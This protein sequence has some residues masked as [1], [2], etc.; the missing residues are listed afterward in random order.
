MANWKVLQKSSDVS[1]AKSL[2]RL[3]WQGS[4]K[5]QYELICT[6]LSIH[7]VHSLMVSSNQVSDVGMSRKERYNVEGDVS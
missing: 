2:C 7:A 5:V 4:G 3:A 1:N 6:P